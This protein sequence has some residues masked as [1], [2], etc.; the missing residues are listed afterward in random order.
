MQ[1]LYKQNISHRV[2]VYKKIYQKH[3]NSNIQYKT[4]YIT[5]SFR[6]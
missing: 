2:P 4:I 3:S 6:K 5:Y 1:H